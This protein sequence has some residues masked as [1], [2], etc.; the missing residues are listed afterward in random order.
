MFK[1]VNHARTE[2]LI[3]YIRILPEREQK[4]IAS[5]IPTSKS[6]KKLS[7]REKKKLQELKGIAEGLR[8]I[9]EAKRTGKKLPDLQDLIDELK[10]EG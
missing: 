9:K 1:E 6:K 7:T 5:S 10:N 8:E 2:A 3:E 4:L